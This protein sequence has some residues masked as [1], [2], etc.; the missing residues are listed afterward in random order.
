MFNPNHTQPYV[1]PDDERQFNIPGYLGEQMWG[2]IGNQIFGSPRPPFGP[3]PP[4][5]PGPGFPGGPLP[6][7]GPNGPNEGG[8]NQPPSAPPP[9]FTPTQ[10]QQG[11]QT[12]AV[13]PG[14]IR[15]CL[16]RYTYIWLK[17]DA[18]WFYPIYVG[19][20][21]ISGYRWVGYRWV[22][23]GIDLNH[24]ESFQCF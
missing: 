5:G 6:G 17:R 3:P 1:H 18:F 2:Y 10:Q 24:I 14:A 4:S 7:Q 21:S 23:Y 19:R 11:F 20:N 16:Y 13:D 8:M 22:Y 9:N 15:G 12:Y